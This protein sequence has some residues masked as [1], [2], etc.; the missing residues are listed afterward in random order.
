HSSRKSLSRGQSAQSRPGLPD[1][2]RR[3]GRSVL[4]IV[5]VI[6]ACAGT[7]PLRRRRT[8]QKLR[9]MA[10]ARLARFSRCALG[11]ITANLRLQFDDIQKDIGLPAQLVGDHWR[12]RRY[13]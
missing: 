13:G 11:G 12:L 5:V 1:P 6:E 10:L 7:G 4:E 8:L 9:R 3:A 2:S